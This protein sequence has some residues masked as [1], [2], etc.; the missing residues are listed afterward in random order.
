MDLLR[1]LDG[2]PEP[3]IINPDLSHPNLSGDYSLLAGMLDFQKELTDQIVSSHYSDI[4]K[5]SELVKTEVS[6][7][8][9]YLID[10]MK[11]MHLNLSLVASHPYLL[12]KHFM[13]KTLTARDM[14]NRLKETSG[15]FKVLGDLMRCIQDIP[16]FR[17][18]GI[19]SRTANRTHD[20][21]EAMLIGY[22]CN[23]KRYEGTTLKK[24][25]LKKKTHDFTVHVLP[26]TYDVVNVEF[27][28]SGKL[29]LLISF[30]IS[31]NTESYQ[32][33]LHQRANGQRASVIRIIPSN[34]VDHIALNFQPH[35]KQYDASSIGMDTL[36]DITNAA[37]ILRDR[38]GLIPPD[39]RPI[40]NTD[41]KFLSE[42]FR[43]LVM[44]QP[45][46]P[47]L[48][49]PLPELH[50]IPKYS[51]WDVE[52]SL[53]TEVKFDFN[54]D[55]E[56][57]G[58]PTPEP[59]PQKN[60]TAYYESKRLR[61]DYI[62]NPL[63]QDPQEL[64]GINLN[65][66]QGETRR[67]LNPN[68]LTHRLIYELSREYRRFELATRELRSFEDHEAKRAETTRQNTVVQ[69]AILREINDMKFLIEAGNIKYG[70]YECN[71]AVAREKI[72]SLQAEIQKIRDEVGTDPPN[73]AVKGSSDKRQEIQNLIHIEDLKLEVLEAS[74]RSASLKQESEYM[75]NEIQRAQDATRDSEAEIVRLAT[76]NAELERKFAALFS[77]IDQADIS[78]EMIKLQTSITELSLANTALEEKMNQ[79][80][81]ILVHR[82]N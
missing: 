7:E 28:F 35:A 45:H 80:L 24:E 66:N 63:K 79:G 48:A 2:T 10:S 5:F 39:L 46:A 32:P 55:E 60:Q 27:D 37:V 11:T 52:K 13:P 61:K 26:S 14:P 71:I 59:A 74:N 64:S 8:N 31:T 36:K 17:N 44:E 34:T 12:I 78:E 81:T 72:V 18:V 19:I 3:P 30:D 75:S 43:S 51:S 1:I 50:A 4:L 21:L 70:K 41:L 33:L 65:T 62:E 38:V 54:Y 53:L 73:E 40:Y 57:E 42:W 16:E 68:V 58:E 25:T 15:K 82:R 67:F 47:R 76:E 69:A 29:D 6:K 77:D 9:S 23:V 20:M 22:K 56:V 49:W